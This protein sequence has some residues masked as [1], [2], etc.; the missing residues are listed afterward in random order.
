MEFINLL[1]ESKKEK[2]LPGTFFRFHIKTLDL[3]GVSQATS[4]PPTSSDL[5]LAASCVEI[6]FA[7]VRLPKFNNV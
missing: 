3:S 4:I 1:L 2:A 7:D 5:L 6:L